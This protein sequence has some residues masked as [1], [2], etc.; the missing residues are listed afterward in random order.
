MGI[1]LHLL[2]IGKEYLYRHHG[3][4]I[5]VKLVRQYSTRPTGTTNRWVLLNKATGREITAK[6]RQ[7]FLQPTGD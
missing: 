7:K 6:S 3:K 5:T 4:T 1:D 2:E